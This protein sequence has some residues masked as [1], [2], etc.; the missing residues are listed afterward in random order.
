[1]LR[2]KSSAEW[3]AARLFRKQAEQ[4]RGLLVWRSRSALDVQWAGD[5]LIANAAV[6]TGA[7]RGTALTF[8][9]A[10]STHSTRE[11]Q[12]H[13]SGRPHAAGAQLY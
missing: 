8:S 6:G 1:M 10:G 4:G 7:C 2:R 9:E 3:P 12:E 13:S 11:R 5:R